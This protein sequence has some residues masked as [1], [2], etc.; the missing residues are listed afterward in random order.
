MRLLPGNVGIIPAFG[1]AS[2][3]VISD[4]ARAQ[5]TTI[6][7]ISQNRSVHAFV[8]V[9]QC[10]ESFGDDDQAPGFDPFN[11]TAQAESACKAA[12]ATAHAQQDSLIGGTQLEGEGTSSSQASA[13]VLNV[14]HAISASG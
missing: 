10:G 2:A 3:L 4:S 12:S 13:V 7:P 8:I 5:Q 14:I 1:L 11:E 9:P 6:E